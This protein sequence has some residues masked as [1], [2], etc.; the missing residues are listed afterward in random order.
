M[1]MG[2]LLVAGVV[3]GWL[4]R[5]SPGRAIDVA[6][7]Q[8]QLQRKEKAAYGTLLDLRD[9]M[10]T[11]PADSLVDYPFPDDDISYYIIEDGE[12]VFWSDNRLD[13]RGV[14]VHRFKD[15]HFVELPN[16]YCVILACEYDRV[17]YAALLVVKYHYPY[18]NDLLVNRFARGF[19]M[20]KRVG[21]VQGDARDAY[22]VSPI[23]LVIFKLTNHRHKL[24]LSLV[25][26]YYVVERYVGDGGL[27]FKQRTFAA[28]E[29]YAHSKI[30][31]SDLCHARM[32]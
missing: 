21:V 2:L 18:E 4:Y 9:R 30:G 16:A 13:I 22:A 26:A 15:W 14:D 19:D 29:R 28:A 11:A 3:C 10:R 6:A 27:A 32:L 5:T 23:V 1:A 20:D 31:Q 25:R 17:T 7:F 24:A 12:L 8:Q